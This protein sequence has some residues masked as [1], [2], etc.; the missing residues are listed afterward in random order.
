MKRLFIQNRK[1]V[2]ESVIIPILL[3]QLQKFDHLRHII[4]NMGAKSSRQRESFLPD[5]CQL[6]SFF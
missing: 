1:F 3:L 2:S 6:H 4:Y 5:V